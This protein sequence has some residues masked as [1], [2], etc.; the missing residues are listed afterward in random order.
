MQR[1]CSDALVLPTTSQLTGKQNV[2]Q[3]NVVVLDHC[4]VFVGRRREQRFGEAI[5]GQVGHAMGFGRHDDDARQMVE[6]WL[7]AR[8]Q[9]EVGQMAHL[10]C[11]FE[12]VDGG[13]MGKSEYGRVEDEHVDVSVGT[14]KYHFGTIHFGKNELPLTYSFPSPRPQN[15]APTSYPPNRQT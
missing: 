9:I 7:Q 15:A 4:P 14:F 2:A 5:G 8:G 1:I 12:S 10:E 6:Q 13:G 3:F 11:G